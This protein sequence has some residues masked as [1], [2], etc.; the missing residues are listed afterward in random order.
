VE[1]PIHFDIVPIGGL[2]NR[3]RAMASGVRMS[4]KLGGTCTIY[5]AKKPECLAGFEE[6][7]QPL[8]SPNMVVRSLRPL[9]MHLAVSRKKNLYFPGIIRNKKYDTQLI[10][11]K[12]QLDESVFQQIKGE[13]IFILSGYSLTAHYPLHELFK[14][15]PELNDRIQAISQQFSPN[16][17]GIHIRRGDNQQSI[18]HHPSSDYFRFMDAELNQCPD[19]LFYLATDS[20]SLKNQMQKRYGKNLL[21]MEGQLRRDSL[22]GMKDAVVDLWCLS[23]TSRIIGSYFSSYSD[24]AAEMGR[25]KLAFPS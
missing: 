1:H 22:Q 9:Q 25:I 2:C 19:A 6:L 14:P 13:K 21:C 8:Q 18:Q 16:T 12:E 3:M 15:L 5:W 24:L 7:F 11:K 20:E 17:I 10:W 23:A 4:E